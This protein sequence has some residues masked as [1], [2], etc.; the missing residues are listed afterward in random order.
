MK[1]L[2][3]ISF[4]LILFFLSCCTVNCAVN[5]EAG[6]EDTHASS[7]VKLD[8]SNTDKIDT[9]VFHLN[10]DLLAKVSPQNKLIRIIH[11]DGS[12]FEA[13]NSL[14]R[15]M[16]ETSNC[17]S[18][19]FIDIETREDSFTVNQMNCS[20][21]FFIAEA[22]TFKFDTTKKQYFLSKLSFEYIDRRDPSIEIPP[23]IF[24]SNDFGILTFGDTNINE[25][26]LL[27]R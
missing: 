4:T 20:G 2:E 19:G 8:N 5:I 26:Y 12:L 1:T 7:I 22:I 14:I 25:L 6:R 10:K 17:P 24:T 11:T 18:D 9:S 23:K 13:N 15:N 21:W 27:N 16:G 3:Q